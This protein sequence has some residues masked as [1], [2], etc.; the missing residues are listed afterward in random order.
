MPWLVAPPACHARVVMRASHR[1]L[2][3]QTT[4]IAGQFEV[5]MRLAA[6]REIPAFRSRADVAC[7]KRAPPNLAGT[8]PAG[9][10]RGSVCRP[11]RHPKLQARGKNERKG[12]GV[13][14]GNRLS[15]GFRANYRATCAHPP[16]QSSP[17][18]ST[19]RLTNSRTSAAAGASTSTAVAQGRLRRCRPMG[20]TS[21]FR[22]QATSSIM[23]DLKSSSMLSARS[24]PSRLNRRLGQVHR[25]PDN[26]IAD[27]CPL[28]PKADIPGRVCAT[29][30]RGLPAT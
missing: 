24:L 8:N 26:S 13:G 6:I 30:T 22:A 15:I 10:L 2:A 17:T 19:R 16:G 29:R 23:I 27:S 25:A 21:S 9:G 12:F 5:C 14:A 3:R 1:Q 7:Q 28:L 18:R 4:E 11:H 20:S